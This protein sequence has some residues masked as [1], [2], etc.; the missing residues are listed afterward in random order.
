M[1]DLD[2]LR[3]L[4]RS[5]PGGGGE[6]VLA[7][8]ASAD[9]GALPALQRYFGED[10][11]RTGITLVIDGQYV[12]HVARADA[13]GPLGQATRGGYGSSAGMTLPGHAQ[14]Q[15]LRLRCPVA[16]CPTPEMLAM[17]FDED[18]PPRCW[19]HA[20]TPMELA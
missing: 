14:Y 18:D 3:G 6:P 10:D 9:S 8:T 11:G 12:G 1:A 20:D 5:E 4:A 19:T 16:G 7:L 17:T 13:I 15:L 2:L